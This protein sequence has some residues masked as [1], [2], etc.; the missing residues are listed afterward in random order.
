MADV[1]TK[2]TRSYNMS[3][4]QSRETKPEVIVGKYLFS[5]GLR[6]RKNDGRFPGKP[7]L[8][9]P[10]YHT[11]VFINGCFWH[12]HSG[13][14]FFVLPKTNSAFWAKKLETNRQRDRRNIVLLNTDGWRVIVIWECELKTFSRKERLAQLYTEIVSGTGVA[15]APHM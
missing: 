8:V 13:C 14:R 9:F 12:K 10:R 2:E 15:G 3:R 1:H 6:Y 5:R 4:I 11:V 7:D